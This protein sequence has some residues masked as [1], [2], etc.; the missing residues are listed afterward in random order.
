MPKKP[1]VTIVE[2]PSGRKLTAAEAKSDYYVFATAGDPETLYAF[3]DTHRLLASWARE[4]GVGND[5]KRARKA[6]AGPRPAP[7]SKA[8]DDAVWEKIRRNTD[9][10]EE[11][12]KKKRISL[13][14]PKLLKR[15][16]DDEIIESARVFEKPDFQGTSVVLSENVSDLSQVFPN[17]ARSCQKTGYQVVHLYEQPGWKPTP[18]FAKVGLYGDTY[19][20]ST[21]V[22][23]RSVRFF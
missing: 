6:L 18:A 21:T 23:F 12:A 22:P 15:A 13:D 5:F 16:H 9:A 8:E 7:P 20:K 4:H 19:V 10:L 3:P 11:Y 1:D 17:G 14:D 2:Y